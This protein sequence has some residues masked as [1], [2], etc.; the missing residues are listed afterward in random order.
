MPVQSE[1]LNPMEV[2]WCE[3]EFSHQ[4]AFYWL[5]YVFAVMDLESFRE[6]VIMRISGQLSTIPSRQLPQTRE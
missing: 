3:F 4:P 1:S 6:V 5:F 2:Y